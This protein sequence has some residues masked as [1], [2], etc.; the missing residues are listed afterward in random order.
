MGDPEVGAAQ[1]VALGQGVRDRHGLHS[2][3]ARRRDAGAGILDRDRSRRIDAEPPGGLEIDVRRRLAPGDLVA[4]HD[5]AKQRSHTDALRLGH[6]PRRGGRGRDRARDT[7]RR[8]LRQQLADAAHGR[9]R[10][11]LVEDSPLFRVVLGAIGR[12]RGS[13]TQLQEPPLVMPFRPEPNLIAPLVRSQR[14]AAPL[15]DAPMGFELRGFAVED[16]A[17]EIEDDG[18]KG[19]HPIIIP[20]RP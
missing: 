8:K 19:W 17:V 12:A 14:N 9:A 18:G 6:H 16:D 4:R 2:G 10:H 1:V 11:D 13:L 5:D 3:R 7:G 15:V 20:V